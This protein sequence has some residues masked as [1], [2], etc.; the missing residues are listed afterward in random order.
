[1]A[2]F[3]SQSGD[4]II[5]QSGDRIIS[6]STHCPLQESNNE[7]QFEVHIYI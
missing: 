7:V 4:R 2:K 3:I 6:Q 5:S 1:M